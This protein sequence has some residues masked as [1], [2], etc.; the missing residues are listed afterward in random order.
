[1]TELS[2]SSHRL[3]GVAEAKRDFAKLI[4]RVGHGEEVVVARHGKP[5]L[6]LCQPGLSAEGRPKPVGLAAVAGVMAEW[7]ELPAIVDAIYVARATDTVR[8]VPSMDR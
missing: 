7:K 4:E 3:L 8:D 1:M 6:R 2:H 5:V